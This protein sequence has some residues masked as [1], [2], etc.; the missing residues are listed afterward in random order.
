MLGVDPSIEAFQS[1]SP[2]VG[3][4]FAVTRDHNAPT[5]FHLSALLENDIDILIYVGTYE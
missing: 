3:L 2:T 4:A 1:C 5:F